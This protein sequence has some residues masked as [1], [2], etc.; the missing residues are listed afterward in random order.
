[1]A[2][3][4]FPLGISIEA[5]DNATA[6]T[7]AIAGDIERSFAPITK[8]RASL[9]GLSEATG[10]PRL[11]SDLVDA[12]DAV[13]N[14][15]R[16]FQRTFFLVGGIAAA[17]GGATLAIVKGFADAGDSA[18][19]AAEKLGVPI[20]ALQELRYAA[21]LDNIAVDDLD[22][23]LLKLTRN[24]G[25]AARGQ[26]T[27][28]VP[29]D[30]LSISIFNQNGELRNSIDIL[31]DV[32]DRF[33]RLD[34]PIKKVALAQ[35]L[36]GKSG[37]KLI[38]LL[39]HGRAGLSE[40]AAEARALGV[41]LSKEDAE[42]GDDFGDSLS[43]VGF[44]AKG[45]RNTIGRE[46]LPVVLDLAN[47]FRAWITDN[48]PRIRELAKEFARQLPGAIA[49]T[50][51]TLVELW[52]GSEPVRKVL[53]KI[54]E[55]LGPTGSAFAILGGIATITLVP[56]IYAT[57]TA[58]SALSAALLTTPAGWVVL[59]LG[60]VAA[61]LL[62][63]KGN[64]DDA[65][66]SYHEYL[67]LTGKPAKVQKRTG[68][69]GIDWLL[70]WGDDLKANFPRADLETPDMK[71]HRVAQEEADKR[72]ENFLRGVFEPYPGDVR[73]AGKQATDLVDALHSLATGSG[74]R[75]AAND[76]ATVRIE[77]PNVP[78]GARVTTSEGSAVDLDLD[79]G[80][81]LQTP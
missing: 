73:G 58:F 19:K 25:L 45:V 16:A 17:A 81:S 8:F 23:S 35:E 13:G 76:K 52:E 51:K 2:R 33:G 56:A 21:D 61:A 29:F 9:K 18:L 15:G 64:A 22:G 59:G 28:L 11:R 75:V 27:A 7:R 48:L 43:R 6:K 24:I 3:P 66:K 68:D 42:A 67:D 20:E 72:H 55:L 57:V 78:R 80:Y 41:V 63:V 10:L 37:A 46:L 71:K 32:A 40:L 31:G 4:V 77:L 50:R 26:K 53:G 12:G 39:D 69:F 49:S 44:A 5:I 47:E 60:G 70:G 1:M 74:G 38:P 36:F 62:A 34:T 14:L 30:R 65:T 54:Y 79:M